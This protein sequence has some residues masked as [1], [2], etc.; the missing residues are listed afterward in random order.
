MRERLARHQSDHHA[1]DQPRPR[2]RGD[3]VDIRQRQL[4]VRQRRDD[5]RLQRL[6]MR[7]RGDL[8]HDTAERGMRRLLPQQPMCKDLP[9]ARHECGGGF[10]AGRFDAEN[11]HRPSV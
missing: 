3:R 9:V 10:V 8:R 5:Q 1:A 11:D 7:T 6:D 4:R 2:G